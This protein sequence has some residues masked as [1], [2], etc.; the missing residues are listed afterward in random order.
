M[1]RDLDSQP[2][3]PDFG[4]F[5][6]SGGG[7]ITEL[8]AIRF[9]PK[10]KPEMSRLDSIA[11][12]VRALTYDEMME[13][14]VALRNMTAEPAEPLKEGEYAALFSRWARERTMAG[15]TEG[16][17]EKTDEK[18]NEITGLKFSTTGGD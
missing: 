2:E 9:A 7:I 14:D 10:A 8:N 12:T 16:M 1:P 11:M 13:W 17:K 18:Y 3:P 4:V 6:G 15:L 5:K